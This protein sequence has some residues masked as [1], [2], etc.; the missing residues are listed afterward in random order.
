MDRT[1]QEQKRTS[2]KGS[3]DGNVNRKLRA[4]TT[5][6]IRKNKRMESL[7]KR[8]ITDNKPAAASED[9]PTSE[10]SHEGKH[11]V[12]FRPEML[13]AWTQAVLKGSQEEA[14]IATREFRRILSIEKSPPIQQVIECK[15]IPRLVVFL[16]FN[17]NP[18]LQLEA[19]WALTNIA[20]GTS[21]QTQ[22]VVDAGI[23]PVLVALIKSPNLEVAEQAVWALGNISGDSSK[24]RD[25]VLA[26]GILAPLLSVIEQ[27]KSF[28][29][30][31]N[32]TWALSNLCR[33]TPSAEFK[34]LKPMLPTLARLLSCRDEEVVQ[35]A[36][37]AFSY[38]S[39][40]RNKKTCL[41]DVVA[42]G[43]APR[44]VELLDHSSYGIQVP[45][46][47]T[48]GNIATGNDAQTDAVLI[49]SCLR[50]LGSMLR[51]GRRALQKEAAWTISNI[52]AGNSSQIQKVLESSC[53]E[54]L[55]ESIFTS[56]FTIRRESAWAICNAI[57]GGSKNQ[58][59]NLAD[60]PRVIQSICHMIDGTDIKMLL[61]CL[62]ALKRILETGEAQAEKSGVNPYRTEVER[63]GGLDKLESIQRLEDDSVY[64][65]AASI[66]EKYFDADLDEDE[67]LRPV[68]SS[69]G[70]FAFAAPDLDDRLFETESDFGSTFTW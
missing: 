18:K 21:Q 68:T 14:L 7:M 37:W 51:S 13:P 52:T 48:V 64:E 46:L 9:H 16:K 49:G 58:A 5:V 36:C 50:S 20:S 24:L 31:R 19:A 54:L 27:T 17:A 55:V 56:E 11:Q 69:K 23:I 59:R 12:V 45:A 34:L 44:M 66:V 29:M 60:R 10:D 61:V 28:R 1:D 25:S 70:E 4:D 43:I 42:T 65:L 47:R 30:L 6:S 22:A 62:D 38:L 32:A 35:D 57:G 3:L 2:L 40:S 26:A 8:R 67:N 39:E 41:A 15:I 53:V 63:V 33:G